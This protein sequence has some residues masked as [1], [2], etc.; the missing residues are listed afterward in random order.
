MNTRPGGLRRRRARALGTLAAL[1]TAAGTAAGLAACVP[2]ETAPGGVASVQLDPV[3][4]SIVVDD[5]LRDTLGRPVPLVARAFGPGGTP[6][7]TPDFRYGQ[8]PIGRDSTDPT[9]VPLVVDSISGVTVATERF[10]TSRAR[11][12][13]RLGDRLQLVDTVDIVPRPTTIRVAGTTAVTPTVYFLCTDDRRQVANDTIDQPAA[14]VRPALR[15]RLG[16]ATQ[17]LT[18]R[19]SGDSAGDSVGVRRYLVRYRVTPPAAPLPAGSSAYV[20][21]EGTSPYGDRRPALYP[22]VGT[23]DVRVGHD[24]TAADGTT[25]ARLRF[26]APLLTR[27]RFPSDTIVADVEAS[28]IDRWVDGA[29][30][31]VP[32]SPVR[33]TVRLVRVSVDTL[34]GTRACP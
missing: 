5:T 8:T 3:N 9:A 34:A 10:V 22:V 20:E 13:A 17:P 6:V 4:P 7:T 14:G 2:I 25:Q 33:F 15:G 24:T 16:T 23:V 32:G 29:P 11:V 1:A 27:A 19:L 21:T 28:A 26:L 30:R 18:V 12:T 31:L